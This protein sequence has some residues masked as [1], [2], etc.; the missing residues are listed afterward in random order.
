MLYRKYE[1]LISNKCLLGQHKNT[2][3]LFLVV[4]VL[5]SCGFVRQTRMGNGMLARLN[6]VV[7]FVMAYNLNAMIDKVITWQLDILLLSSAKEQKSL[8]LG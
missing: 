1:K 8:T 7:I 6:L 4:A 5:L 3:F 2:N